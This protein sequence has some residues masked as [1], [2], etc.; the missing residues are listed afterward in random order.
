MRD[1][2]SEPQKTVKV[3]ANGTVT[4]YLPEWAGTSWTVTQ[5]DKSLGKAKEETIPGFAGPTT[6]AHQFTWTVKGPKGQ[7]RIQLVNKP[8]AKA[9]GTPKS[10][11]TFTLTIDAV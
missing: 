6:P 9:E 2:A 10:D 3:I 8:R 7:H 1:P 5:P 11:T 4:L